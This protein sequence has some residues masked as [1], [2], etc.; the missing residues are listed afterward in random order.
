MA[1]AH[2]AAQ[3]AL[4][5]TGAARRIGYDIQQTVVEGF[6][7]DKRGRPGNDT[8]YRKTETTIFTL[9]FTVDADNVA[10]TPPPTASS[11]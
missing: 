3:A 11:P 1:A 8:C 5:A 6:R 7:Q 2:D 10:T 9:T 4:A